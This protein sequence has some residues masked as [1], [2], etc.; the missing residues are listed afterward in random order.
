MAHEE[1]HK[2]IAPY[3]LMMN[4]SRTVVLG[5]HEYVAPIRPLASDTCTT[6]WPSFCYKWEAISSS[7]WAVKW[8]PIKLRLSATLIRIIAHNVFYFMGG[9]CVCI[10][11]AYNVCAGVEIRAFWACERCADW[12]ANFDQIIIL[13]MKTSGRRLFVDKQA[14]D[15]IVHDWYSLCVCVYRPRIAIHTKQLTFYGPI[16]LVF[17]R[18][19]FC[20]TFINH[21]IDWCVPC[22]YT[23]GVLKNRIKQKTKNKTTLVT[24]LFANFAPYKLYFYYSWWT[25]RTVEICASSVQWRLFF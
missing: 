4:M 3:H 10:L 7:V 2:R 12:D 24:F 16:Q 14:Y 23:R 5:P 19:S 15:Y 20:L 13:L 25:Q 22:V 17:V 21:H 8:G 9:V 1:Q 11:E 18:W 6:E